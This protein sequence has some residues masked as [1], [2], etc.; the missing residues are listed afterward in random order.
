M[1]K[2]GQNISQKQSLQQKLSP[3]QIQF[4]K[5]LQLPTIGLEQRIKEEIEMNPVLEELDPSATED[6]LSEQ[7]AEWEREQ[8]AADEES[9]DE[10]P[11]ID[12]SQNYHRRHQCPESI[13][14]GH[15]G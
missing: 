6:T 3:Q 12:P 13:L 7:E 5:L 1:L 8:E 15:Q 2:T 14:D 10:E 9:A 11:G 4:V